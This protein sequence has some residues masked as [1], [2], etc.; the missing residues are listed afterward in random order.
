MAL[1]L[2]SSPSSSLAPLSPQCSGKHKTR[3]LVGE[4][5]FSFAEALVKKHDAKEKHNEAHSLAKSIIATEL[6]SRICCDKCIPR[7]HL[8]SVQT[9]LGKLSLKDQPNETDIAQA[10]H[11]EEC[12][13]IIQ[14]IGSLE[15]LGMQIILGFDGTRIAH[16]FP[17]KRF[18]RIHWNVPHD[19]KDITGQ[20]LPDIVAHFFN[21][22]SEAQVMGDRVHITVPCPPDYRKS[23]Y[24]GYVYDLTKAASFSGYKLVKKR[25]FESARYPGYK[26]VRT[27]LNEPAD[28]IAK[29]A[30][31][32]IFQK[33][34]KLQFENLVKKADAIDQKITTLAKELTKLSTKKSMIQEKEFFSQQ[35]DIAKTRAYFECSS[36]EESS[37]YAVSDSENYN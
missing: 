21:S 7:Q 10:T 18:E 19:G 14:R 36:D 11:C 37:D 5:N 9:K 20:T 1:A 27:N 32:F 26:H 15:K 2:T 28:I 31:E 13:S 30:R 35:P 3:L 23:L 4:G 22:C 24:Q 29:G 8:Y 33:I 25:T 17:G 6:K 34:D 12:F 16:Y